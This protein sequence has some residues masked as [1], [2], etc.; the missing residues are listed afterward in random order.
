MRGCTPAKT[1]RNIGDDVIDI[2]RRSG[3][4]LDEHDDISDSQQKQNIL[5]FN[6]NKNENSLNESI[7]SD[8]CPTHINNNNNNNNNNINN[9]DK[10]NNKNNN[11]NNDNNENNDNGEYDNQS[12]AENTEDF[13]YNGPAA[14]FACRLEENRKYS[15]FA[16]FFLLFIHL[17]INLSIYLFVGSFF[18]LFIH[19]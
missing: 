15:K 10:N 16:E 11:K 19:L 18:Y 4:K 3:K 9:D 14:Q 1:N 2:E 17:F 5:N 13:L 12:T 8:Y 7:S 6:F